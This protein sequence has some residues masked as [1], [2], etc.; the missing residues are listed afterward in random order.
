MVLDGL[1]SGK[2]A[3]G[4]ELS[5]GPRFQA[6]DND[7]SHGEGHEVSGDVD[8]LLSAVNGCRA[9][10]QDLI[11][12]GV[13]EFRSRLAQSRPG[14]SITC[15]PRRCIPAVPQAGRSAGTPPRLLH[16]KFQLNEVVA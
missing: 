5:C 16:G 6:R 12:A 13:E 8:T 14:P 7:W 3:V 2:H 1:T 9:A 15:R 11:G 4:E 10:A